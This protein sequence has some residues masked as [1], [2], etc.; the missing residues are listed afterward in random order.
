MK[1]VDANFFSAKTNEELEDEFKT[2]VNRYDW[3]E[4]EIL[5]RVV[6]NAIEHDQQFYAEVA[7]W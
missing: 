5:L 3:H 6:N 1:N 2:F 4:L 7:E